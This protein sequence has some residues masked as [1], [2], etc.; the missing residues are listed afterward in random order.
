MEGSI[1][2]LF[3]K[4]LMEFNKRVLY[5]GK[6]YQS[7]SYTMKE[8]Q[9]KFNFNKI[10]MNNME[11]LFQTQEYEHII[12]DYIDSIKEYNSNMQI[13]LTKMKEIDPSIVISRK[14]NFEERLFVESNIGDIDINYYSIAEEEIGEIFHSSGLYYVTVF[15]ENYVAITSVDRKNTIYT[16]TISHNFDGHTVYWKSDDCIC[17]HIQSITNAP[18]LA[19]KITLDENNSVVKA[20]FN[21]MSDIVD[22]VLNMFSTPITVVIN[23]FMY[24]DDIGHI[25]DT[26]SEEEETVVLQNTESINFTNIF[27]GDMLIE[28]PNTSFDVYLHLLKLAAANEDVSAI[29]LTLYRIGDNPILFHI[30]SDAVANRIAVYVNIELYASREKINLFWMREMEKVGIHVTTY[31]DRDKKVHCKSTLIKFKN[32]GYITQVGTGNYHTQTTNQYTDFSLITS[33][34]MIGK[35]VYN[36]F[37]MLQGNEYNPSFG[38]TFLVTQHNAMPV[39]TS[40]IEKEISLGREGYIFMKCNSLNDRSIIRLLQ[41][42]ADVGC[43]I[44]LV[45]RSVCTWLPDQIGNNV[46]IKSMVWDKLEHSRVYCF[47]KSDPIVYI[48]SLDMAEHKLH[49]RVETLV[50]IQHTE[51]VSYLCEYINRCIVNTRDSWTM[52]SFG[53]YRKE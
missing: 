5:N 40:L 21:E 44:D 33:N 39:L 6:L 47:N 15:D 50:Q 49:E 16:D 35:E 1:V 42:A 9:E 25:I 18:T 29:Y 26:H 22:C 37:E 2:V 24:F 23:A 4:G 11:E 17:D 13:V 19:V 45:I 46:T 3:V 51:L 43:T 34:D 38:D 53:K 32:G 48:G 41:V 20:E 10:F 7:E 14:H 52:D 36:L 27:Q 8:L 31:G 30:L 12:A 28:Y